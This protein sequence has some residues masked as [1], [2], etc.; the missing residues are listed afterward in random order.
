M[1]KCQW[2]KWNLIDRMTCMTHRP[3][4]K[5]TVRLLTRETGSKRDIRKRKWKQARHNLP[6]GR[7]SPRLRCH[8]MAPDSGQQPLMVLNQAF[9]CVSASAVAPWALQTVEAAQGNKTVEK[10]RRNASAGGRAPTKLQWFNYSLTHTQT[11]TQAAQNNYM[12]LILPVMPPL[13]THTPTHDIGLKSWEV[14]E[15]VSAGYWGDKTVA[16]DGDKFMSCRNRLKVTDIRRCRLEE[17]GVRK[18]EPTVYKDNVEPAFL[19]SSHR[20]HHSLSGE[21]TVT[22][23]DAEV[24]QV[25]ISVFN[26][27]CGFCIVA[28]V[29]FFH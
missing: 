1:H 11:H 25:S 10:P 22:W 24:F 21:V 29:M 4:Q 20:A 15:K 7:L 28:P 19:S 14:L 13:P 16:D 5:Q 18:S 8:S 26:S 9:F 17:D 3:Q 23:G 2:S 6:Q 12:L 27:T